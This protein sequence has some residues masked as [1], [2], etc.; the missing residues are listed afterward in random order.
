MA[1]KI[2]KKC[3]YA[4]RAVYEV[5]SRR[6]TAPVPAAQIADAQGIPPRFLENIM[7]E[8]CH[9]GLVVSHRGNTGG[10]T[11]ASSPEK[12]AVARTIEAVEGPLSVVASTA[13][14]TSVDRYTP[15]DAAFERLWE[16]LNESMAKV[17]RETSMADLAEWEAENRRE[18]VLDYVI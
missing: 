12:M 5:A 8:L 10:Y 17:C 14:D 3:L 4:L 9:A 11:L 1:I 2:S 6:T 13:G 7:N 18:Y 16:T 15:G